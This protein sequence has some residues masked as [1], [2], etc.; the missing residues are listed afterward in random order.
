MKQCVFSRPI[1]KWEET[2]SYP[3]PAN[4]F[5]SLTK[6]SRQDIPVK[7]DAAP[8]I[9]PEGKRFDATFTRPYQ[10]HA[11]IGPSCAVAQ[12]IDGKYTIWSHTQGV[13]PDQAAIAEML[14]VGLDTLRVIHVEGSG[15]YGHNGADDAAADAALIARAIPGRPVRVQWT[16]EQEHGWEPYGP[17]MV[18]KLSATLNESGKISS[19]NHE[20]WSNPHSTRPGPAGALLAARHLATPFAPETPRQKPALR[21]A[22]TAMLCRYTLFQTATSFG[23]S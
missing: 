17:A 8:L 22:A 11:S 3:D 21:A 4:L 18:T 16:R 9:A 14:G 1:A 6:Q 15:C 7:V 13:F 12:F 2:E 5:N 10:M 19:W 20:V 23:I